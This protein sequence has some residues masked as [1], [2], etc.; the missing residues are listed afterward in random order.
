MTFVYSSHLP[1]QGPAEDALDG[2]GGVIDVVAV[3]AEASLEAEGVAGAEAADVDVGL[4][5]EGAHDLLGGLEMMRDVV[6]AAEKASS[7]PRRVRS[8][9]PPVSY[10]RGD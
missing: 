6:L 4:V 5:E 2:G 7:P 9:R 10:L 1:A 8:S 3:Q